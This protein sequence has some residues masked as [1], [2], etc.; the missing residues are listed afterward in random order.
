MTVRPLHTLEVLRTERLSPHLVRVVIGGPE[1]DDVVDVGHVD[2]YVKLVIPRP[3]VTYPEPWSVETIQATLPREHWPAIRTYTV[4]RYDPDAREMWLDMVVHG[5]EGIA[6]PWAANAK[7]GDVVRFRGPGGAYTPDPTADWHLLAGDAAALPAIA[8][9]LEAIPTDAV[10]EAFIEVDERADVLDLDHP[11]Q[12][13]LR[14]LIRADGDPGFADA[15]RSMPWR[16][17]RVHAFVHGEL[18]D[19]RSLRPLLLERGVARADLSL[20]GYWRRG[21]DEDGFQ[22]EKHELNTADQAA[23]VGAPA[24]S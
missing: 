10:V 22:K 2:R 19:T 13:S 23:E 18:H 4:R 17:G 1:F 14:W 16:P 15:V 5:D 21:K 20:S 8:A 24:A 11:P 3:G 7:P 9:A 12:T 6:G